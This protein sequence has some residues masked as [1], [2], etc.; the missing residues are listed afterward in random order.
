MNTL[1]AILIA[2]LF[3]IPGFLIDKMSS[4]FFPRTI[5]ECGEFD[6]TVNCIILS[7]VVMFVNII[8]IKIFFKNINIDTIA[9]LQNKLGEI[10]FLMTYLLLTFCIC[11]ITTFFNEH[12]FG[13]SIL[14]LN[15]KFRKANKRPK[16]TKFPTVWDEIFENSN[17]NLENVY[18]TIEKDGEIITQG[19]LKSHSPPNFNNKELLLCY[20]NDIKKILE[21]DK[22]KSKDKMLFDEIDMEYFNFETGILVKIYDMSKYNNYIESNSE[23]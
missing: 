13:K 8:F 1:E 19:T 6:K 11:I 18:M 21:D 20:T 12:I 22:L 16:E 2:I 17:V 9:S 7:I 14:W 4:S 3:L 15:N 23:A 5:K 10:D